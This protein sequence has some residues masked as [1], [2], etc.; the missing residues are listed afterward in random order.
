[1]LAIFDM[2]GTLTNSATLLANSINYVR[3]KLNLEPL[4]QSIVIEQINNPN[5]DMAKFFYNLNTIEPIHE[6][7]FKEYYSANHNVELE[8]YSGVVDMLKDLKNSGIYLAVA[9]NAYRD[10]TLE[11]LTHLE[12]LDIFDDIICFDD[13]QEP[14]PSPDMLYVLQKSFG[15]SSKEIVFVGDSQRD[16]L[17]AKEAR[18]EF[19]KVAFGSNLVGVINNPQDVTR[20]ME[21]YFCIIN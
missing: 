7:W 11:A 17:A 8:L 9:T 14:K 21:E 5:C 15:L 6:E 10:S 16:E 2:D 4:E 20:K 18:I 13:V 12:I 19:I 3:A 1:V